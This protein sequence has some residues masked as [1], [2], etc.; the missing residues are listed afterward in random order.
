MRTEGADSPLTVG[1]WAALMG[2]DLPEAKCQVLQPVR[3]EGGRL[4]LFSGMANKRIAAGTRIGVCLRDGHIVLVEVPEGPEV[5]EAGWWD[6]GK[7]LEVELPEAVRAVLPEGEQIPCLLVERGN[8]L[9][10]MLVRVEEHEPDVLG[11]RIIDEV[12]EADEGRPPG[13]VRH[14]VKGFGYEEWSA[15]RVAEM[16]ALIAA[17]PFAH[18]PLAPLAEGDDWIAWKTRKDILARPEPDDDALRQRLESGFFAEQ[19]KSGSW[20]GHVVQTAYGILHALS[21]DVPPDD[22]RIQ[23][24]AQWLL[25]QPEPVGRP[26]MWM[27]D[28]ARRRKWDARK[29]GE[30][31]VEWLEFMVTHYTEEDHDLFRAQEA[32][33]IIPSC[34]RNHHA[35]C[36]TMLHPSATAAMALCGCGHAEHPRVRAYANSMYQLSAMFGYFC[37]CWGILSAEKD[38]EN[39]RDRMPDFDSRAD[40]RPIAI[41]AIPYG[42][43]RDADDLCALAGLPRYPGIHRPDLSDTNGWTPYACRDIGREGFLALDGAYWQN[44]DCWAK[45]N[46]A[47]AQCPGWSGSVAELF[48]VFQCHLYQTCLGE[49]NQG[50]PSGIFRELA[51]VTRATRVRQGGEDSPLVCFAA[52]RLLLTVPWLR[53]H[54]KGDGLWHFDELSRHGDQ[55]RPPSPRLG[56]YHICSA[57]HE[58]GLLDPLVLGPTA[59]S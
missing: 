51:E 8:D 44:A 45:P 22:A 29:R 56:T 43:G 48:A 15:D 20:N 13:I 42:H 7:H 23:R 1:T 32:Q 14:V 28:E 21:V 35:G 38:V 16:A 6:D 41:V 30:E 9:E 53:H 17:E 47:L 40:E 3:V 18:D 37:A 4:T 2:R 11:P 19:R 33:Q 58:F 39:V 57:L 24:A 49:W 5:Q 27:L 55:G 10:L 54:Q 59:R 50:Y 46:R 34:T 31:E 36:D 12:R 52:S 26:G 25:D